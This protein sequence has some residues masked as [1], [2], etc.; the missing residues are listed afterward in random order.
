MTLG[1]ELNA[2]IELSGAV[3]PTASTLRAH[4][5]PRAKKI[6][7]AG[8]NLDRP[9]WAAGVSR[10]DDVFVRLDDDVIGARMWDDPRGWGSYVELAVARGTIA[11]VEAVVGTT[12]AL[13]R[14][15]GGSAATVGAYVERGDR[16][17]R[18]FATHV[19][20][21]VTTVTIHYPTPV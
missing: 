15:P 9:P 1:E 19:G 6:T 16:T 4:F 12:A 21:T 2:L 3:R 10:G 20:D 8:P 14:E 5:E 7:T 11:D 17:L 13:P 18:V